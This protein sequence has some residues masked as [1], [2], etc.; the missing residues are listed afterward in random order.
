MLNEVSQSPKD[1]YHVSSLMW[2]LGRKNKKDMKI[3][4]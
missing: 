2:N 4:G 1:N 3:K